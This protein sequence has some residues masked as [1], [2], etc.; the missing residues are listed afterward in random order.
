MRTFIEEISTNTVLE[1]ITCNKCKRSFKVYDNYDQFE[2]QEMFHYDDT[3]G[4]SSLIG[5][6]VSWEIDL[7]QK[8]TQELL[9]KYIITTN[10]NEEE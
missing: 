2:V 4:Y 7:C 10:I 5:D 6:G 1:S 8:C 9:G 3:G